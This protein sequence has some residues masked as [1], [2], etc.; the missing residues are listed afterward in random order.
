MQMAGADSPGTA[1]DARDRSTGELVQ[2]VSELVAKL[3]R[4]EISLAQLELKEKGKRA[5]VGAGLFGGGGLVAL[6]GV[7][8][9]VAA[10]V[11]GLAEV[12]PAWLAALIVGVV[13]LAVAGVVALMGKKQVERAVPPVPEQAIESVRED[14]DV[15]KGRAHR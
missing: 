10:A 6:Y 4:E 3:V 2:Q 7:G 8:A 1:A 12:V 11:L 5:G 14:I 9:L 13:L 15:V